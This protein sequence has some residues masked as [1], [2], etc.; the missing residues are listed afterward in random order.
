MWA[1]AAAHTFLSIQ[2]GSINVVAVSRKVRVVSSVCRNN[3]VSDTSAAISISLRI[4]T[5]ISQ[6]AIPV[7]FFSDGVLL[8]EDTG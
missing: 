4:D 2:D 8:F 6:A 1:G 3:C 5:H 7:A